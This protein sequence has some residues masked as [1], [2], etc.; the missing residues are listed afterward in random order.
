MRAA[1]ALTILVAAIC[2]AQA[3]SDISLSNGVQI[4]ITAKSDRGMPAALRVNLEPATGNSFYRIYRDENNL[5]IFAYELLVERTADGDH[6]CATAKPA[7]DE[8][9]AKFPNAD[10]GK[11]TPTLAEPRQSALL[12]SGDQFAIEIADVPGV[13]EGLRDVLLFRLN[14]RG[15]VSL[16]S[17]SQAAAALQFVGLK[18]Q[19]NSQSVSPSEATVAGRY[20]MFYVPGRGGYFLSSEPVD[21]PA[22]VKIGVVDH[23]HVNFTLDNDTYDCF[24]NAP[25]LKSDR[26]EIWAFH[27]PNYKPSGNWTSSDP[28]N[29]RDEFFA[30]AAD[31]LKWWLP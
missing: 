13:A 12:A 1:I 4:T 22:F 27:H 6:F 17:F 25:I 11:P 30:A 24:S 26:A 8:F 15:A 23:G 31:S 21:S 28:S 20:V 2:S 18:V 19:I 7:G 14:Q 3:S 5:A 29:T 10:G 9:A 16:E